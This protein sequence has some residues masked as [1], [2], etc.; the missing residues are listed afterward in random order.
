MGSTNEPQAEIAQ[1]TLATV[2][3]LGQSPLNEQDSRPTPPPPPPPPPTAKKKK[4]KGKIIAVGAGLEGFVDWRGP[5]VSHPAEE[6]ED[7]MS[8]LATGFVGQ[9]RKRVAS[10]QGE[11]TLGSKVSDGKRP[12]R[13]GPDEEAQKSLAVIIVDSIE[14]APNALPALDG[15]SQDASGEACASLKDGVPFGGSPNAT[16]VDGE[17]LSI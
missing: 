7:D 5:N 16:R 14:R 13:S 6:R 3:R 4:K 10:A 9:M 12:K 17:A 2:A 15:V 8:S 1:E 11:T